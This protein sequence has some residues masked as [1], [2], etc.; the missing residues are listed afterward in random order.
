MK[1]AKYMQEKQKV[2]RQVYFQ[3]RKQKTR[4]EGV[5]KKYKELGK[6]VCKKWSEILAR[7][8]AT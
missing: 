4:E 2:T 1:V 6:N 8:Y 7:E 3:K 5:Q